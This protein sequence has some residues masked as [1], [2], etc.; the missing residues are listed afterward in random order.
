MTAERDIWTEPSNEGIYDTLVDGVDVGFGIVL[1]HW[2]FNAILATFPIIALVHELGPPQKRV[3]DLR[4]ARAST[5][6]SAPPALDSSRRLSP[7]L[8]SH[9]RS[10]RTPSP[11]TPSRAAPRGHAVPRADL[12]PRSYDG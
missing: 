5:R 9:D 11:R 1:P 3:D 4:E 7:R 2:A 6:R 12:H 8:E 10:T